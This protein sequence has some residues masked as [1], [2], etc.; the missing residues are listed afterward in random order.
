MICLILINFKGVKKKINKRKKSERKNTI[1]SYFYDMSDFGS[2]GRGTGIDSHCGHLFYFV[3]SEI[4]VFSSLSSS[5][6][7]EVIQS[8]YTVSSLTH[9]KLSTYFLFLF[10]SF[11]FFFPLYLVLDTLV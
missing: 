2:E 8:L 9:S 3:S 6:D 10:R 1:H 4:R 7:S 11:C 5:A